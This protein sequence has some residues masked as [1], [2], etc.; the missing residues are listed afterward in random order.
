MGTDIQL[1]ELCT[2]GTIEYLEYWCNV[3]ET[4]EEYLEH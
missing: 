2:T 3:W 4:T 1:L